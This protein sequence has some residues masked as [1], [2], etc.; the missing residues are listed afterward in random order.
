MPAH[1]DLRRLVARVSVVGGGVIEGHLVTLAGAPSIIGRLFLPVLVRRMEPWEVPSMI[2]RAFTPPN[3][4][5]REAPTGLVRV[6]GPEAL[7]Y[8][9]DVALWRHRHGQV[10]R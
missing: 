5:G 9:V 3:L 4:R 2:H 6:D 1:S 10:R 8:A 7:R